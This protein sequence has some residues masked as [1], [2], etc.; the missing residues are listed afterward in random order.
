MAM[1]PHCMAA[2]SLSAAVFKSHP[3]TLNGNRLVLET[4]LHRDSAEFKELLELAKKHAR[5]NKVSV[6]L[7]PKYSDIIGVFFQRLPP[8]RQKPKAE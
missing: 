8:G 3:H 4:P 1:E 6:K 7:S 5:A 2:Q